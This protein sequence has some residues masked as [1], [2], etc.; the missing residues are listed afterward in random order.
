MINGAILE[1]DVILTGFLEE[2]LEELE[3]MVIIDMSSK[4]TNGTKVFSNKISL[5]S[6]RRW[7][8]DFKRWQPVG[9]T[10]HIRQPSSQPE[11]KPANK[12]F[13][14]TVIKGVAMSFT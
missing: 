5:L 7:T 9:R 11:N 3:E 14:F 8:P 6:I 13:F 4:G 10:E 2:A 1:T 12:R